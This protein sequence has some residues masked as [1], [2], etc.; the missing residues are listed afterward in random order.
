MR[1]KSVFC[2]ARSREQAGQIVERLKES[3][4]E[5]DDISVLMPDHQ[6][7]RV[8]AR[9]GKMSGASAH[10]TLSAAAHFHGLRRMILPDFGPCLAAGPIAVT[11]GAA[12]VGTTD[13]CITDVLMGM[14]VADYEAQRYEDKVGEGNVFI[15]AHTS[16]KID[17]VAEVLDIYE[18]E[19]AEYL[20][21]AAESGRM[22]NQLRPQS[23]SW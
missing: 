23:S 21:T 10:E 4:F 5:H 17:Q 16:D 12:A 11:L 14:G 8:P 2:V 3:G 9:N 22:R 1:K 18:T 7:G 20:S 15:A 19:M 6:I 13:A